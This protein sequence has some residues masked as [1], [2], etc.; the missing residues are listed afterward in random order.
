MKFEPQR[1]YRYYYLRFIRL[2]GDPGMLARGVA[3]GSF[4]GITPTIPFHTI[5]VL[6]FALLFRGSKV[7]GILASWLVS[8][9]LTFFLQ[10]YLSWKIGTLI[11]PYKFSW[12]KVQATMD[13]LSKGSFMEN[14]T[15][16]NHLGREIII[17]MVVGGSILALPIATVLYFL[18][19]SFFIKLEKKQQG[20]HILT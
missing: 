4:I 13:F 7:A 8:N 15:M 2:K 12:Q 9:P 18:S 19:K 20:K 1:I 11:T 14:I 6:F 3:V 16:I 5:L 10:Y 17:C